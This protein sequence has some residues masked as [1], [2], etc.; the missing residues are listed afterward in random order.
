MRLRGQT[1]LKNNINHQ[2]KKKKNQTKLKG[3]TEAKNSRTIH[4]Y[5]SVKEN[6]EPVSGTGQKSVIDLTSAVDD[7]DREVA[8]KIH[9]EM[10]NLDEAGT[11][12][13]FTNKSFV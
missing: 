10:N 12:I 4:Q 7:L 9:R 11:S 2:V 1:V 3:G 8:M 6:T 13:S 5:F